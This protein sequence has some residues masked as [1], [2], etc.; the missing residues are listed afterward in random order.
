MNS[1]WFVK[2]QRWQAMCR[3]R[4]TRGHRM[5]LKEITGKPND[6]ATVSNS[7]IRWLN[8]GTQQTHLRLLHVLTGRSL[9]HNKERNSSVC[10]QNF[11]IKRRHQGQ[12]TLRRIPN[13]TWTKWPTGKSKRH[14]K[15]DLG[16]K[17][18]T[19]WKAWTCSGRKQQ[20]VICN[21]VG[22]M[23][24]KRAGRTRN[25]EQVCHNLHPMQ[26]G[27]ALMQSIK[28]ITFQ[29]KEQKHPCISLHISKRRLY[30]TSQKPHMSNHEYLEWFK[31]IIAV[32][33][34]NRGA[35]GDEPT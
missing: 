28:T 13:T 8:W 35:V 18:I 9:H 5:R 22:A 32:I 16:R 7:Q 33:E 19:L 15:A 1:T 31:N 30:T 21:C 17:D 27:I 2:R 26:G 34:S 3:S 14:P 11:S 25:H 20:K 23:L 4:K 10:C 29:F 24:Q 6:H 12:H